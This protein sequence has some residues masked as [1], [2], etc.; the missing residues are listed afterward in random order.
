[1]YSRLILFIHISV[2]YEIFVLR[3]VISKCVCV[4]VVCVC[5]CAR[6]RAHVCVCVGFRV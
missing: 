1:M 6:A 3:V 2:V 5:L 4:F